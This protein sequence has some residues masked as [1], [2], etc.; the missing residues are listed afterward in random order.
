MK[1]L[2]LCLLGILVLTSCGKTECD[3]TD[4]VYI[5]GAFGEEYTELKKCSNREII[6]EYS[7]LKKCP[8]S[9]PLRTET[10]CYSCGEPEKL[11]LLKKEDNN[12]CRNR[13]LQ[14]YTSVLS[15]ECSGKTPLR[16]DYGCKS[17]DDPDCWRVF[18]KK[19]AAAC[20]KR[21]LVGMVSCPQCPK[22]SPLVTAGY[23][24]QI[25]CSK[26]NDEVVFSLFSAKDNDVCS[27]R[28]VLDFSGCRKIFSRLKKCPKDRPLKTFH[29]GCKSCDD[30]GKYELLRQSD[31]DVCPNRLT[32]LKPNAMFFRCAGEQ[33]SNLLSYLPTNQEE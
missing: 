26:C 30:P 29:N 11:Q 7:Y 27:N 4:A 24:D 5:G 17:C 21:K 18:S 22:E 8:F 14:N 15:K 1:K 25:K 12:A 6:G 19:D 32:K 10:G 28:E 9:R 13:I 16:T 31:N 3:R 33:P 20:K 2:I 23:G